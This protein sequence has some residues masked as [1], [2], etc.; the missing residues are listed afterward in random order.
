MATYFFETLTA[1]QALCAAPSL[2]FADDG[3]DAGAGGAGG[4]AAAPAAEAP[5]SP[6]VKLVDAVVRRGT[7]TVGDWPDV[8]HKG[9]G[10]TVTLSIKEVEKLRA[11]GVLH[12]APGDEPPA[13]QTGP[14]VD[15]DLVDPKTP[16]D[17]A[18]A[19]RRKK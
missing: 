1:A 7:V 8:E 2:C 11:A 17:K 10:E 6:K 5:A 14:R 15:I 13:I 16:A 4:G 9:P 12:P 3:A 18:Q 19:A